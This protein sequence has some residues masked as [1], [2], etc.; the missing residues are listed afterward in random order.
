MAQWIGIALLVLLIVITIVLEFKPEYRVRWVLWAALGTYILFAVT[1]YETNP[2]DV[3]NDSTKPLIQILLIGGFFVCFMLY[4]VLIPLSRSW[5]RSNTA[6]EEQSH[7]R[8]SSAMT[9]LKF[10]F[11]MSVIGA[12]GYIIIPWCMK[13]IIASSSIGVYIQNILLCIAV[14]GIL[15]GVLYYITQNASSAYYSTSNLILKSILYV[16]CLVGDYLK[17]WTQYVLYEIRGEPKTT[18]F[19]LLA[20][21][22]LIGTSVLYFVGNISASVSTPRSGIMLQDDPVYTDKRT[23]VGNYDNLN[24]G[25]NGFLYNYAISCWFW[26][27]PQPPSQSASNTVYTSIINYGNTP[28]VTYM[29]AQNTLRITMKD[30]DHKIEL[31]D[32]MT[33]IPLQRWNNLVINYSGGTLDVFLNGNLERTVTEIIPFKSNEQISIGTDGGVQGGIC[34]VMYM[35][36]ALDISEINDLYQQAP[37]GHIK[38]G[39]ST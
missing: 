32:D 23:I 3:I 28:N 19:I 13:L 35:Q 11:L 14:V 21:L 27:N 33:N 12:L 7:P 31:M 22:L 10:L 36:N 29:G 9:V 25:K 15:L 16:P 34:K 6:Y 24:Q 1:L 39:W 2:G 4:R 17:K 18:W 20:E 26:V 5:D 37:V 30:Q 8:M 38:R